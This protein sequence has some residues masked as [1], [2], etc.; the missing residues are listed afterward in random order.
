MLLK[1]YMNSQCTVMYAV[2]FQE[3]LKLKNAMAETKI[4]INGVNTI[5]D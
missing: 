4:T 2:M 5:Y 1:I 3:R